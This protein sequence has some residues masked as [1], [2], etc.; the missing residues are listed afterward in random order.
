MMGQFAIETIHLSQSRPVILTLTATLTN[1]NKE[2]LFDVLGFG[3]DVYQ[4]I[5]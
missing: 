4:L 3:K 2:E 5:R 1:G